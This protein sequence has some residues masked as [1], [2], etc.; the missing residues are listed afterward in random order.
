M[1]IVCKKWMKVK[2]EYRE[3]NKEI[4]KEKRKQ[5]KLSKSSIS[6]TSTI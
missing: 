4:L 3:K 5:K 1:M 2:K 6:I